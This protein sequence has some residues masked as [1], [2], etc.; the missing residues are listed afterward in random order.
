MYS[1]FLDGKV[2]P[3]SYPHSF[4]AFSYCS[5]TLYHSMMIHTVI[6]DEGSER[7][8]VRA[9]KINKMGPKAEH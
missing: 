9:Y 2:T 1:S 4:S 3:P 6:S 5:S 7:L 8:G